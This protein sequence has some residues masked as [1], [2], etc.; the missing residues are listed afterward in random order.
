MLHGSHLQNHS[1]FVFSILP[2]SIFSHLILPFSRSCSVKCF[3]LPCTHTN[4]RTH[5]HR[6]RQL[7]LFEH[8]QL[9]WCDKVAKTQGRGL[10]FRHGQNPSAAKVFAPQWYMATWLLRTHVYHSLNH[11]MAPNE[12]QW[13]KPKITCTAALSKD[14]WIRWHGEKEEGRIFSGKMSPL[15]GHLPFPPW[16]QWSMSPGGQYSLFF[17]L[18]PLI[19]DRLY[20]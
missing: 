16:R 14:I 12:D 5:T 18:C 19:S 13:H 17:S 20:R 11:F 3:T 8:Q 10:F 15:Q 2:P 7:S 4:T 6:G 9:Y 1:F